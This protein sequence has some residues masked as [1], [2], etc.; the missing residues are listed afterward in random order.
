MPLSAPHSTDYLLSDLHDARHSAEQKQ[1]RYL[2]NVDVHGCCLSDLQNE[3]SLR[4][5]TRIFSF[6]SMFR[7]TL[8]TTPALY[9]QAAGTRGG[10]A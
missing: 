9:F 5:Y 1:Y 10:N 8:G 4:L 7:K 6:I 2:T 3:P